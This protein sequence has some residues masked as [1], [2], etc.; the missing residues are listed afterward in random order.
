MFI[1]DTRQDEIVF[2]ECLEKRGGSEREGGRER[3]RKKEEGWYERG[4]RGRSQVEAHEASISLS[5]FFICIYTYLY[6]YIYMNIY[7]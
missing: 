5:F 7:I 2:P 4:E 1:I 6:I 3:E